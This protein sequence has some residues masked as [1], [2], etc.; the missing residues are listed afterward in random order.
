MA[1]R[2]GPG[3]AYW[4]KE[5][6]CDGPLLRDVRGLDTLQERRRFAAHFRVAP[7]EPGDVLCSVGNVLTRAIPEGSGFRR[8]VEVG[9]GTGLQGY[10]AFQVHTF[11]ATIVIPARRENLFIQPCM[12]LTFPVDRDTMGSTEDRRAHVSLFKI[13][14]RDTRSGCGVLWYRPS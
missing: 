8:I 13:C 1:L 3:C 10:L 7:D 2:S 6:A 9:L 11:R 14:S 4:G 5:D 12:S